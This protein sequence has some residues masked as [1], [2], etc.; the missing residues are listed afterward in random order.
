MRLQVRFTGPGGEPLPAG[1]PDQLRLEDK[2][3]GDVTWPLTASSD[4]SVSTTVSV[5]PDLEMRIT[6]HGSSPSLAEWTYVDFSSS[7]S[8]DLGTIDL[9]P[10]GLALNATSTSTTAYPFSLCWHGYQGEDEVV[11]YGYMVFACM[12]TAC[13]PAG[14]TQGLCYSLTKDGAAALQ[15]GEHEGYWGVGV[16][17]Q[18]ADGVLIWRDTFFETPA[19]TYP[20][21]L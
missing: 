5:P 14:T 4:G 7:A 12:E 8:V 2:N 6:L 15:L 16:W 11:G 18:R 1:Q 17:V 3:D 20:S 9:S 19:F 10:S 21:T 13:Y